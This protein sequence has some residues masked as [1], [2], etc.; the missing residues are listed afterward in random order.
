MILNEKKMNRSN[1]KHGKA[2]VKAKRHEI[3]KKGINEANIV[4]QQSIS[5]SRLLANLTDKTHSDWVVPLFVGLIF[6]LITE[7]TIRELLNIQNI[8]LLQKR[9]VSAF[10]SS[11]ILLLES[12]VKT[13]F[14][15]SVSWLEQSISC[16]ILSSTSYGPWC[17]S[18]QFTA[19][20]MEAR[21][22]SRVVLTHC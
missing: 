22:K 10:L 21:L 6:A 4:Q 1:G 19:A 2:I 14:I 17:T 16:V 18:A 5:T 20:V 11:A 12:K 8:T 13:L 3:S 9:P 7:E 15:W